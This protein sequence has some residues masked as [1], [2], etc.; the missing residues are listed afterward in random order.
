MDIRKLVREYTVE[1]VAGFLALLGV[2]LLVE[3]M[4][5]RITIIRLL[6][7]AWRA[8]RRTTGRSVEAVISR[9]SGI[10]TSD[11]LG[12]LL[13]ALAVAV[14]LWRVRVRLSQHLA[15]RTCP[16]CG[17]DLRRRHRRWWDRVLSILVPVGRFRC[18]NEDCNW[19]GL[20]VQKHR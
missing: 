14:I 8:I 13:I 4:E 10:T 7:L 1:L 20:R 6:R 19:E 5:I 9:I 15:G 16:V 11:F 2:F 17:S 12:L 18:K 3:Q